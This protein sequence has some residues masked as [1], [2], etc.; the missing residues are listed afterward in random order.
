[1][2]LAGDCVVVETL[3]RVAQ[4]ELAVMAQVL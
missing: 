3:Q 4:V 2:F 1:L